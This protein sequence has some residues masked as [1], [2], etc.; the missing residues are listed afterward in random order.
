MTDRIFM[1]QGTI[2]WFNATKGYGFIQ[3]TDGTADVFVHI[4][5]M[6]RAGIRDVRE[7]DKLSYD[8]MQ[9]QRGKMSATN[10]KLDA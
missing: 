2:K 7:G 6:E 4:S 1:S 5:D 8:L 10:L 3:P 9:G